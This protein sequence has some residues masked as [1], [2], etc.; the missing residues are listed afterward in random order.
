MTYSLLHSDSGQQLVDHKKCLLII[1]EL[2]T[3]GKG[4]ALRHDCLNL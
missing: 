1:F 3:L 2:I 4:S